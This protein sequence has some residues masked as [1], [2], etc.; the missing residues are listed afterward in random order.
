[1]NG[2]LVGLAPVWSLREVVWEMIQLQK[3]T[4]KNTLR[5][6]QVTLYFKKL[7]RPEKN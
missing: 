6:K 3:K 2:P 4:L 7:K 5:H 1:M